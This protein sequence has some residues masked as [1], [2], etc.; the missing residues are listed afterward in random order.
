LKG[1][2]TVGLLLLAKRRGIITSVTEEIR[3]LEN[4]INF[5]L[6]EDLKWQV[7]YEAGE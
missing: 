4:R 2:G 6:S 3:K 7:I 1:I 5:R